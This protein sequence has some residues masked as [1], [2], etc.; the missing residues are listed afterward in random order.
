[1][2]AARLMNRRMDMRVRM[3]TFDFS[4]SVGA[5]MPR[6]P[7]MAHILN[8]NSIV[9][10]HLE[11][12]LNRVMARARAEIVGDDAESARIRSDISTFIKQESCHYTIH[13]QFNE[14]M[15]RTGYGR[16]PELEKD[17]V[18][19]YEHLLATKSLP[20]LVAY[21]EGFESLLPPTASG[22]FDGSMDPVMVDADPNPASMWRWHMM[23]EFEHRT[24]CHDAF[25]RVHG[26]YWLRFYGYFYQFIAL[27]LNVGKV[28][29]Y[30]MSVDRQTM[31]RDQVKQSKRRARQAIIGFFRPVIKGA[32]TILRPG[33]TP[34]QIAEPQGWAEA[35]ADIEA[36]WVKERA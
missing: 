31:S 14:M 22:W 28:Y 8:A 21:C 11:R 3:P 29:R 20:F 26:G 19:H 34:R 9:V 15:I 23:E 33:Y 4:G 16:L 5:W 27:Q 7:E 36:N 13:G 6:A 18:A 32:F 17:I 2:I 30:L 1:M 25:E 35:R 10:P 12:F 24:V